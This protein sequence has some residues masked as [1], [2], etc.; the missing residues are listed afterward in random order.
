MFSLTDESIAISTFAG[1]SRYT[2]PGSAG[3]AIYIPAAGAHTGIIQAGGY[4]ID[5]RSG[6]NNITILRTGA[7]TDAPL[8][9]AGTL[10]FSF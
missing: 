2:G 5:G 7:T 9:V 8:T 10:Q 6:P 3:T 4:Y 1:I